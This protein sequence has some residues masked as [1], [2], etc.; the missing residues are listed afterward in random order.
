[1]EDTDADHSGCLHKMIYMGHRH[2]LRE[3]HRWRHSRR[4]FNGEQEFRPA[5]RRQTGEEILEK[6]EIRD[7]FIRSQGLG[8]DNINHAED[9]VRVNGV[10]QRS[11]LFDLPYWQVRADAAQ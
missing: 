5:P 2:Y 10:K 7:Q 11:V 1:M 3:G 6:A 9:P 4:A 8:V